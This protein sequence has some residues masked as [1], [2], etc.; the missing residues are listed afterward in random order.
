[1]D[2]GVA[3]ESNH[4]DVFVQSATAADTQYF[5]ANENGKT[6]M[7]DSGQLKIVNAP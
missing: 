6:V 2:I 1:M 4:D 5:T 7:Y 3:M